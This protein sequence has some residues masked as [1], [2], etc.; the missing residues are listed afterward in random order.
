LHF[1]QFLFD[2]LC[3]SYFI[4]VYYVQSKNGEKVR[5][6]KKYLEKAI[7]FDYL[8]NELLDNSLL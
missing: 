7:Y 5:N 8:A 1:S 6:I 2:F 3:F 4:S